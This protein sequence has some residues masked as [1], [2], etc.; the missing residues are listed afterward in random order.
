[1]AFLAS[2]REPL[3]VT[4]DRIEF[5]GK[6]GSYTRPAALERVGLTPRVQSGVDPCAA[7]QLLLWLQPGETKEVTFMLGQ[8]ENRA[9]AEQ[10]ISR[11]QN[12]QNVQAAWQTLGEFWD[13]I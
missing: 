3:G 10:L 8:G 12:I 13:E 1:M 2:T 4:T 11:Y 6:H 9:H 7:L 5:L